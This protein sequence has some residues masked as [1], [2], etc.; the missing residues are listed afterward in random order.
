MNKGEKIMREN[1]LWQGRSLDVGFLLLATVLGS[2]LYWKSMGVPW[3]YDDYNNIVQNELIRDFDGA[4]HN[5]FGNRGLAYITFA[6]NYSLG[7]LSVF[8]YHLANLA[9]H[10]IASF[11]V[12]LLLHHLYEESP[13]PAVFG[14][15]IFLAHPLQT[16]A[17]TYIVQRMASLA[18][19][20][21]LAAVLFYVKAR[22]E[23]KGR[24]C[25]FSQR[26]VFFY[27]VALLLGFASALTKENAATL[28]LALVL[29][30]SALFKGEKFL[31]KEKIRYLLPFVAIPVFLVLQQLFLPGSTLEQ[32]QEKIFYL[33]ADDGSISLNFV[34][35]GE[36]RIRALFTQFGILWEY[37]RLFLLPYGQTL[38]YGYPLVASVVNLNCLLGL[39]AILSALVFAFWIR[40]T[41]CLITLG[42]F[43]FF[44]TISTEA[45]IVTLDPKY[46]HRLY[47]PMLG[48]ILLVI[49]PFFRY[50]RGS[51]RYP[52]LIGMLVILSYLT[53]ARNA[54]WASP[55]EFWSDNVRK[56]PHSYIPKSHL[57]T[58]LADAGRYGEALPLQQE[59]VNALPNQKHFNNLGRI[60]L[61]LGDTANAK[62]IFAQLV[63][64]KPGESEINLN[65]SIV[66]GEAGDFSQALV[67][68]QK[69]A[70]AAPNNDRVLTNLGIAY[71]RLGD[72]DKAEDALRRALALNSGNR[73]AAA[74]LNRLQGSGPS[75]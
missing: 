3:Y 65:Y 75:R 9:V 14:A 36:I 22:K 55:I 57:A 6:I 56:A 71:A 18:A 54:L 69:A 20:F 39:A 67:Y 42:I 60:Y 1:G 26:H 48:L 17:V 64:S 30:D 16:Q 37:V 63:A 59:V 2:L 47:L 29:V 51:I 43:W 8:G 27:V 74:T 5:L 32:T 21:Y 12:Y 23:Y 73:A 68:G 40:K 13:W 49:D 58:A 62:A 72:S 11:I 41:N 61:Q 45:T 19:L 53:F 10:I 34:E 46:E 4:L 33:T 66:L 28:P 35:A 38:E 50:I 25:F 44:T 70:A 24:S 52:L 31:T 15:L 7:E